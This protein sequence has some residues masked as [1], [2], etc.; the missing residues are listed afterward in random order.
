MSITFQCKCCGAG[1]E[2]EN[3]ATITNFKRG[4]YGLGGLLVVSALSLWY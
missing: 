4:Q 1:L 3:G 2:F